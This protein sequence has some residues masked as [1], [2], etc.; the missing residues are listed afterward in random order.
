[1]FLTESSS[2]VSSSKVRSEGSELFDF[3]AQGFNAARNRLFQLEIWRRRATGTLA[4]IL[5]RKALR[6]DIGARLFKFRSN[7]KKELNW[8][9]PRGE[10][11]TESFVRGI[12]AYIDLTAK[13]QEF[14]SL[15]FRLLGIKP[16][17]WTSA[18]VVSRSNGLFR[19]ARDEMSLARLGSLLG[20]DRS[21]NFLNLHPGDPD[22]RPAPNLDLKI[23]PPNHRMGR[24]DSPLAVHGVFGPWPGRGQ[25]KDRGGVRRQIHDPS[26]SLPGAPLPR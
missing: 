24:E 8:Y 22:L 19:N 16:G 14:L 21:K 6:H 17:R 11:I 2:L 18:V 3:F 25:D 7:L 4:E 13:N 15:E 5:G 26:S 10:E 1:M 9:H 23:L 20:F 12:N